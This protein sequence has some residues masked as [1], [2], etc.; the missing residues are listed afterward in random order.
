VASV[1]EECQVTCWGCGLHLIL[2]A[3][4]PDFKC[5]W[6]GAI[7]QSNLAPT[8]AN[9]RCF[10]QWG[11]VRDR[12]FVITLMFFIVFIISKFIVVDFSDWVSFLAYS[13]L[14]GIKGFV[15]VVVVLL[16]SRPGGTN[17]PIFVI[18]RCFIG[19]LDV[20]VSAH[21]DHLHLPFIILYC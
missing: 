15:V 3:Y 10:S 7:T 18:R 13:N 2:A 4:S 20:I 19:E 11:R 1:S 21:V 16:F 9:S 6:C 17:W 8:R 5:G 12:F 14:F